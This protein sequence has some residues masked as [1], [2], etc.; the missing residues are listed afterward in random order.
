V[1]RLIDGKK[2]AAEI[3]G[4]AEREVQALTRLGVVPSLVAVEVGDDPASELYLKRQETSCA[5]LGIRYQRL[6]LEDSVT[7]AELIR[8][9][10]HLNHRPDVTGIIIQMPLPQH[11]NPRAARRAISPEKDVEGVQPQNLG[12]LL[13]GRTSLVPCTAAAALACIESTDL[14]LH[15]TEAVVVGHSETVGKPIALL[16]MERLATVTVCHH[17]TT[18][19]ASHTSRADLLVVAV[20]KPGLISSDTIKN[21][22]VVIDIGINEIERDGHTE[23]VGDVDPGAADRASWMTPVPGGVGPVTVAMLLRNTA[24]AVAR[25]GPLAG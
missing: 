4:E 7:E 5:R 25:Q 22:A 23:V 24:R 8:Q 3:R 19:L 15:G 21:G 14:V 12:Y 9:I 6:R 13:S 11:V 20:G 18:D 10:G 17:G 2:I 16:L 1:A